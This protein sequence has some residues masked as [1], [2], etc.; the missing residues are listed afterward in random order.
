MGTN[1]EVHHLCF[2]IFYCSWYSI[3]HEIL[4]TKNVVREQKFLRVELFHF[5]V[6]EKVENDKKNVFNGNN[7]RYTPGYRKCSD[8]KRGGIGHVG[9]THYKHISNSVRDWRRWKYLY[10]HDGRNGQLPLG[11]PGLGL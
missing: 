2:S 5:L 11:R 8:R 10:R 7:F 3:C 6:I 1:D 4:E 9:K